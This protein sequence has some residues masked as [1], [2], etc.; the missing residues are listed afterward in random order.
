MVRI[1]PMACW[2]VLLTLLPLSAENPKTPDPWAPWRFLV[3]EWLGEGGGGPGQGTGGFSFQFDLGEKILVRKN[4]ADYP[5]ADGKPAYHHEDLTILYPEDGA[6]KATFFDGEGHVIHY[7]ATASTDG[8]T[9][10]WLSVAVRGTP[11]YRFTYQKTGADTV[12]LK[13][14]IAPP[15]KPEAFAAYITAS[16]RRKK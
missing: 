6:I 5:P 4:Y 7:A 16:A 1:A 15:D 2:I 11:R 3:G 12:N 9:L 10:T 14:E 13:F 8:K